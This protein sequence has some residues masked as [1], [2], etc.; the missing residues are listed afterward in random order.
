MIAPQSLEPWQRAD[1]PGYR[2]CEDWFETWA[3][4]LTDERRSEA[5]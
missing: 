2:D 1:H 4:E 3:R 5:A